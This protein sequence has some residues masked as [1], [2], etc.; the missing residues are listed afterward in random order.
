MSNYMKTF[1]VQKNIKLVFL[2]QTTSIM[3]TI[4]LMIA[5]AVNRGISLRHFTNY[6]KA[7]KWLC[8]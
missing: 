7:T 1:E 3:Q 6:D 8:Q 5:K 2:G 4:F